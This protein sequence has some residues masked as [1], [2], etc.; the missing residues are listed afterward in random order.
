[1]PD[2]PSRTTELSI[3]SRTSPRGGATAVALGLAGLCFLGGC[4]SPPA[5]AVG[6]ADPAKVEKVAGQPTKITLTAKAVE[7]LGIE[8]AAVGASSAGGK[9]AVP[10]AAVMYDPDGKTFVFTNPT[11]NVYLRTDITVTDIINGMAQLSAGPA[12]GTRVVTVGGAELWG[13]ETGLG[14]GH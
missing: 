4:S 14:A 5:E 10:A 3:P 8:T 12:A 6:A 1:M 11:A 2:M 9:A 7:R 13:A